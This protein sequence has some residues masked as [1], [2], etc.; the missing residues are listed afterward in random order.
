LAVW[1]TM[2]CAPDEDD[3]LSEVRRHDQRGQWIAGELV[4]GRW[5]PSP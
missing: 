2:S 4:E 5:S 3:L 1:T